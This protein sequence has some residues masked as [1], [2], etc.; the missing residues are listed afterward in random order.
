[1]PD[2]Y[3]PLL[4]QFKLDAEETAVIALAIA[5]KKPWDF[6]PGSAAEI[7]LLKSAKDKI[8]ILHLERHGW[9]CCYCRTNLKGAG[10]FMT[11]REHILPKGKPAYAKLS[12]ALWNLAAACKRCNIQFKRS[13]D[14]FVIDSSDANALLASENY[15]FVHPN[16]DCWDDHLTRIA[17]Q[18]NAKNIVKIYRKTTDKAAYTY[19]F[20]NLQDLEIDSF[21]IAQGGKIAEPESAAVIE[22]LKIAQEFGQ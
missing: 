13:G 15:R 5:S 11:D 19:D 18:V 16:F 1:M 20:F 4:E 8:L 9:T 6:V 14:G 21:N 10:P 17:F 3:A 2:P 22:F 12:Y 7:A